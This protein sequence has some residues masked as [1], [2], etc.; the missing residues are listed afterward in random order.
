MNNE[1]DANKKLLM[2]R[3]LYVWIL[4]SFVLLFI[5]ITNMINKKVYATLWIITTLLMIVYLLRILK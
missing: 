2:A 1:L 5:W 4:I 3:F